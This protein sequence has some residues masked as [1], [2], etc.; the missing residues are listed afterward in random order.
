[1]T[2]HSGETEQTQVQPRTKFEVGA[3]FDIESFYDGWERNALF[4]LY[5]ESRQPGVSL[6]QQERPGIHQLECC[7]KI[8]DPGF[9]LDTVGGLLSLTTEKN[10]ATVPTRCFPALLA[11]K[12]SSEND[13][14]TALTQL[15]VSVSHRL[16][17]KSNSLFLALRLWPQ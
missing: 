17:L 11:K 5:M 14:Y 2:K 9:E 4:A 7:S 3:V 16:H 1:M 8:L 6:S 12:P 10:P 15:A 13:L